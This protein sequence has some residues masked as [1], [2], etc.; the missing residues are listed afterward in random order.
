MTKPV[1][2]AMAVDEPAP[3]AR[4]N[5]RDGH[6]SRNRFAE[7]EPPIKKL[8]RIKD[9]VSYWALRAYV[10]ILKLVCDVAEATTHLP[11]DIGQ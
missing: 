10:R 6:R 5:A 11:Q 4:G 1:M 9:E 3:A 2:E 7:P 8:R